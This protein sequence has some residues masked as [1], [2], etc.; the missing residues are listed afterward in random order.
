[1]G[2]SL[3]KTSFW[4]LTVWDGCLTLYS[5]IL[6]TQNTKNNQLINKLWKWWLFAALIERSGE[7]YL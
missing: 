5:V 3:E 4:D 6:L 1:M 2:P 7:N